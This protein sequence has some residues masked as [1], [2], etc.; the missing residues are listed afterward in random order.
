MVDAQP[1]QTNRGS[2]TREM[3]KPTYKKFDMDDSSA[4]VH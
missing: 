3:S 4:A 1:N 2:N